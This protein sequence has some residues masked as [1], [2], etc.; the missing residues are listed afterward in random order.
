MPLNLGAVI[1]TALDVPLVYCKIMVYSFQRPSVAAK[2][3]SGGVSK[4][5][6]LLCHQA[7]GTTKSLSS[8][9][10]T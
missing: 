1:V 6:R 8:W 3:H 7:T 5:V 2:L 9:M 4:V 10:E